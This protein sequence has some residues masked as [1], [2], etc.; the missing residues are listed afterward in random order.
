MKL[1]IYEW[2]GNVTDAKILKMAIEAKFSNYSV[3]LSIS[4]KENTSVLLTVFSEKVSTSHQQT[5]LVAW[6]SGFWAGKGR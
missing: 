1:P 6:V 5:Y 2:L 4:N 3:S